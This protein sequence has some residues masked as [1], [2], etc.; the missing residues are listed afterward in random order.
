MQYLAS[1]KPGLPDPYGK[2]VW[3]TDIQGATKFQS[4]AEAEAAKRT[5]FDATGII[6]GWFV[7]KE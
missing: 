1:V 4:L 3:V 7:V 5:V 6:D 2:F